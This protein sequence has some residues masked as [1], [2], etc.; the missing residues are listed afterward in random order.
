MHSS[1]FLRKFQQR[2]YE[3]FFVQPADLIDEISRGTKSQGKR[4]DYCAIL[5]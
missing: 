1:E 3:E 4:L 2:Y 5:M